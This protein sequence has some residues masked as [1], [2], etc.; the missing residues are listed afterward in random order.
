MEL[1]L[2]L[3][4]ARSA[5]AQRYREQCSGR[6]CASAN[7][8]FFGAL[9]FN[10]WFEFP[11]TFAD[12]MATIAHLADVGCASDGHPRPCVLALQELTDSSM[13]ILRPRLR[14]AGYHD[15]IVEQDDQIHCARAAQGP[16]GQP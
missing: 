14:E 13:R 11:D 7:V 3:Q 5:A 4:A 9:S 8:S 15:P 2:Q 6:T 10:V 16:Q 1:S 12:R